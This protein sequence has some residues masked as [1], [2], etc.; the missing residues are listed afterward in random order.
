MSKIAVHCEKAPQAI[1]PYSHANIAGNLVF[2]SGQLPVKDG[3]LEKEDI[4]KA[5]RNCMENIANILESAG[6]SL[7]EAVK[8][9]IYLTD[10][11]QFSLVNEAYGQFFEGNYP[12]RVCIEVAALPQGVP[13]EIDCIAVKK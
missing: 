7:A 3:V 9:T 2:V 13:V 1:G 11:K 6:S 12:S 5:T 10:M 8:L 4:S